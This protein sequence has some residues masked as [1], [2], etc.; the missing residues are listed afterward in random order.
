MIIF[1]NEGVWV[2]VIYIYIN[3]YNYEL[4]CRELPLFINT[5]QQ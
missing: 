2:G 4:Y 3:L 5:D 1:H